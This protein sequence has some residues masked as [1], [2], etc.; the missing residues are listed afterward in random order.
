VARPAATSS[1]T[2]AALASSPCIVD[3]FLFQVSRIL[4][5]PWFTWLRS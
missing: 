4:A 2:R 5:R 1:T 3:T